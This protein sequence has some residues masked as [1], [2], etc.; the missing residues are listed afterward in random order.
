MAADGG[1]ILA[2]QEVIAALVNPTLIDLRLASEISAK[3]MAPGAINIVWNKE[4][5]QLDASEEHSLPPDK[6]APIVVN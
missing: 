4:A 1:P 5:C 2:T 6:A 3:P